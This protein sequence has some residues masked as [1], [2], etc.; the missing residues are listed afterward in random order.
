MAVQAVQEAT[1]KGITLISAAGNN[2][3]IS[4][5]SEFRPEGTFSFADIS[6]EAHDFD[7]GENIDL[8]QDI[9]VTKDGTLIRPLLSWD[10]PIG[11]VNSEYKIFCLVV[12]SFQMKTM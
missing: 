1:D 6:F 9:E 7:A 3:N 5:E 4:Y 11:N 8:F 10:E 12:Q 2:G